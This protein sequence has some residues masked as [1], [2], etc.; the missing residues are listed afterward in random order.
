MFTIRAVSAA[1]EP[2][3]RTRVAPTV[4]IAEWVSSPLATRA[5]KSRPNRTPVSETITQSSVT[6]VAM[7]AASLATIAS[8]Q[9]AESASRSAS[10]PRVMSDHSTVFSVTTRS[11]LRVRG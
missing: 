10:G 3:T 6:K 2:Q 5:R 8:A 9:A 7:R 1:V 11:P 4:V